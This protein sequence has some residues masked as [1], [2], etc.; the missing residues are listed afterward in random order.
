MGS[1]VGAGVGVGALFGTMVGD[2]VSTPIE[3]I[4]QYNVTISD[5]VSM[6]EFCERYTIVR[7]DGKIF[8]VRE[9]SK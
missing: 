3:Y 6:A 4:T 7:Q 8:T 5:E 9:K 1:G 2:A